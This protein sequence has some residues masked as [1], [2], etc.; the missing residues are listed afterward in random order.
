MRPFV[1]GNE[2]RWFHEEDVGDPAASNSGCG[3]SGAVGVF[4]P[5]WQ[6]AATTPI[7]NAAT[8]VETRFIF[9]LYYPTHY[10]P[11]EENHG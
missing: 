11:Q 10:S 2:S 1:H 9:M 4:A 6:P 3:T 5:F 7:T 8:A